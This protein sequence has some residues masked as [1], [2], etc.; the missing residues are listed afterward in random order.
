M[1]AI[2]R[3]LPYLASLSSNTLESDSERSTPNASRTSN[4]QNIGIREDLSQMS[5]L[6]AIAGVP[7]AEDAMRHDESIGMGV[8]VEPDK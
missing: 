6:S 1:E 2:T 3:A 5:Q 8:I 4:S 7:V